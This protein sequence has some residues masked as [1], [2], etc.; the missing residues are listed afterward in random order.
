MTEFLSR[1]VR[2]YA[3]IAAKIDGVARS[4]RGGTASS[5]R[6]KKSQKIGAKCDTQESPRRLLRRPSILRQLPAA[7]PDTLRLAQPCSESPPSQFDVASF[8]SEL[9]TMRASL[10]LP[11]GALEGP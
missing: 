1:A 3:R 4:L 7:K 5:A 2:A 8:C 11:S 9:E 10:A 6:A